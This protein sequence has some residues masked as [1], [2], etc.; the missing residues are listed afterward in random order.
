MI[1]FRKSFFDDWHG[2]GTIDEALRQH[3]FGVHAAY[4]AN[5]IKF[6]A[7][8]NDEGALDI[9]WR[10][11]AREFLSSGGFASDRGDRGAARLDGSSYRSPVL[12]RYEKEILQRGVE[13]DHVLPSVHPCM[14]RV[15]SDLE[16]GGALSRQIKGAISLR[17]DLEMTFFDL[18]GDLSFTASEAWR[19]FL[20]AGSSNGFEEVNLG[21][22]GDQVEK[23]MCVRGED[24]SI[25]YGFLENIRPPRGEN[26]G[27]FNLFWHFGHNKPNVRTDISLGDLSFIIPGISYYSREIKDSGQMELGLSAIF[28]CAHALAKSLEGGL[29]LG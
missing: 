18:K 7:E 10:E 23:A 9:Y 2:L 6:C 21:L 19:K 3:G 8:P 22:G 1:R 17:I 25:L 29:E 4:Q 27:V 26:P 11:V 16:C 20:D 15:L 28:A 5:I 24:N 12:D 14:L 13:Y